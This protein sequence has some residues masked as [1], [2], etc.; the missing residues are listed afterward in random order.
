MKNVTK[1]ILTLITVITLTA[2]CLSPAMTAH[3]DGGQEIPYSKN[4]TLSVKKNIWDYY[5]FKLDKYYSKAKKI[6]VKSSN[7]RVVKFVNNYSF[8]P[9]KPGTAKLYISM[10][11][12]G[13]T[14]KF[15]SKIKVVKY[16]NPVKS[17]KVGS[18]NIASKY[19]KNTYWSLRTQSSKPK[20]SI[21]P[22][23]GRKIKSIACYTYRANG[24][25]KVKKIKNNSKL[26]KNVNYIT[27]KM[28]NKKTKLTESLNLE[29]M[30]H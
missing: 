17:F 24:M 20:I 19:K 3:A 16:K 18:K 28:Y 1:K 29:L 14:K 15:V 7:E 13:K 23:S 21:K 25:P 5:V 12:N 11:I 22:A 9:K 27:V 30:K 2:T 4:L 8:T 10:K 6:T 26:S